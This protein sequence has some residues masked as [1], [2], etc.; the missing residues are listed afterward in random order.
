[1]IIEFNSFLVNLLF[2]A[3]TIVFAIIVE[4]YYTAFWT[5]F[6]NVFTILATGIS[7]KL[8]PSFLPLQKVGFLVG[9]NIVE[10]WWILILYSIIVIILGFRLFPEIIR[11]CGMSAITA[12]ILLTTLIA[13]LF[14]VTDGIILLVVLIVT[15]FFLFLLGRFLIPRIL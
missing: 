15:S 6:W 13:Q 1:M 9:G 14:F 2:L 4:R 11:I 5:G 7:L 8:I 10:L 3:Q 12:G